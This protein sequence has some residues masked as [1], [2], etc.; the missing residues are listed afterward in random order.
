MRSKSI[1]DSCRDVE[2]PHMN[3]FCS[4]VQCL[5]LAST[6]PC[7]IS[8]KTV[9]RILKP[10]FNLESSQICRFKTTVPMQLHKFFQLLQLTTKLPILVVM[11][12]NN[13][14]LIELIG[15]VIDVCVVRSAAQSESTRT[16][17]Y[18]VFGSTLHFKPW[19][20]VEIKYCNSFK[21][22]FQRITR[23]HSTYLAKTDG[24]NEFSWR[25]PIAIYSIEPMATLYEHYC[26]PLPHLD[27]SDL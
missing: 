22:K 18:D 15:P 3:M 8:T 1:L 23:R 4:E 27:G 21:V 9:A 12:T 24:E 13:S 10:N 11:R 25:L 5:I 17:R 19:R 14:S 2:K 6:S 16:K 26:L 20:I 7:W